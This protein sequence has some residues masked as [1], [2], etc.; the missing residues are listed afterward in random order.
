MICQRKIKETFKKPKFRDPICCVSCIPM[1]EIHMVSGASG[2]R[3]LIFVQDLLP[4][5][6]QIT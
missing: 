4:S 3:G 5:G 2:G 6:A 1:S